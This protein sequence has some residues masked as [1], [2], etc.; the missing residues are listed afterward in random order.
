[1]SGGDIDLCLAVLNEAHGQ[2]SPDANEQHALMGLWFN[3]PN[4]MAL[5]DGLGK[6]G[7][8]ASSTP[9]STP[10]HT[11]PVID[12]IHTPSPA[13]KRNETVESFSQSSSDHREGSSCP[14]GGLLGGAHPSILGLGKDGSGSRGKVKRLYKAVCK[15]HK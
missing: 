1:M 7:H 10:P 14:G 3:N 12:P 11:S 5:D 9:L 4:L 6:H 8:H 13:P 2:S 15:S